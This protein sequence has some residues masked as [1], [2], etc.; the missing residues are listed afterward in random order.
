VWWVLLTSL[1]S[2][3]VP[4]DCPQRGCEPGA[5]I[6]TPDVKVDP[7]VVTDQIRKIVAG[8]AEDLREIPVPSISGQG[9]DYLRLY[10]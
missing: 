9:S 8:R 7:A 4:R 10:D 3:C 2:F 1:V 5:A 6:N